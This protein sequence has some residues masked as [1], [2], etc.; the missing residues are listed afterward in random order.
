MPDTVA[1]AQKPIARVR[2]SWGGEHRFDVG[3]PGSVT[4]RIDAGGPSGPGP[5]D[6]FLS[7][8]AACASVDVVDIL[9]KRRTPPT[10]LTV[11]ITGDRANAIPARVTRLHL[12]Y[13]ID[14]LAIDR[15]AA[16]RAIDLAVSKYCSVRSSLDPAIPITSSLTLNGEP[17][18]PIT[19]GTVIA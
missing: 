16:E 4:A 10:R 12:S 6:T 14:G 8:L 5:V 1:P 15:G 19:A 2:I 9:T 17:G 11:D 18:D 3:R 13:E 7:A